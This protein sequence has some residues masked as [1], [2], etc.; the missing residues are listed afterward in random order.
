MDVSDDQATRIFIPEFKREA[1]RLALDQA[2]SHID[3]VRP[4][5]LRSKDLARCPDQL[6]TTHM[7]AAGRRRMTIEGVK[8]F[9][10]RAM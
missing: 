1:A 2:Y 9:V 10:R 3:A 5:R 8:A 6:T 4:L 7:T